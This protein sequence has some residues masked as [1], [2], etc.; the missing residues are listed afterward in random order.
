MAE[1]QFFKF[2]KNYYNNLIEFCIQWIKYY[3][4]ILYI[5]KKYSFLLKRFYRYLFFLS[6]FIYTELCKLKLMII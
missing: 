6:L 5:H 1:K 4:F 2:I 3:E